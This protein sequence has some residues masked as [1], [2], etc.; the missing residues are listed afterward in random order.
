G[1]LGRKV[2]QGFLPHLL[3][4]LF[5]VP[6]RR[7]RRGRWRRRWRLRAEFLDRFFLLL[8]FF[9]HLPHLFLHDC[10]FALQLLCRRRY[11]GKCVRREQTHRTTNERLYGASHAFLLCNPQLTAS[12]SRESAG[13]AH[14][15]GAACAPA[16]TIGKPQ[17]KK[18]IP[19][20]PRGSSQQTVS[21][22][23]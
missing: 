13:E 17:A 3:L 2:G 4:E 15:D 16:R 10:E 14:Q 20:S 9:L 12:A 6:C 5:A 21:Q 22:R 19:E 8:D 11:L 1:G 23:E 7:R 18:Y